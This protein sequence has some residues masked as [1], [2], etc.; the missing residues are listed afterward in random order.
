MLNSLPLLLPP[1]TKTMSRSRLRSQLRSQ[2]SSSTPL[3]SPFDEN[4]NDLTE[5]LL[6][7][8]T[9]YL[10]DRQ[11]RLSTSAQHHQQWV[12]KRTRRWY[13]VLA[14]ALAGGISIM[15]EKRSNRLGIAQQMFVR[16]VCADFV[17]CNYT[18]C[19][20]KADCKGRITHFQAIGASR[21]L[22]EMSS[23]SHYGEF[24]F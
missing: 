9:P 5:G 10:S 24:S 20:G 19:Y 17:P 4:E 7:P 2:L 22:M 16:Y 1:P 15:F 23:C 12:R 11:A 8:N 13:S 3:A 21:Y 18:Q 6:P 14:G